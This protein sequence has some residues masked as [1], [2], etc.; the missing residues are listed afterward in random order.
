MLTEQNMTMGDEFKTMYNGSF[1]SAL[2]WPQLDALWK[3]VKTQPTGWYIYCVGE[4]LP[5]QPAAPDHLFAFI[6]E[7]DKLL[8]QDHDYDYC[9]IVYADNMTQPSLI[10]IYDPNNLGA[11][12]GSSGQKV[13]PRWILSQI[14]PQ[15][16]HNDAPIPMNRKR[17]W[18]RLFAK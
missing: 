2:R 18:S 8:R 11:S 1:T 16:I 14:I 13:E 9:G 15:Q 17:W 5:T 12:C 4:P 6:Q 10:K 3:Q 7:V